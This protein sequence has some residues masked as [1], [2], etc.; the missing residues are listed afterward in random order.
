MIKGSTSAC[1]HPDVN[2]AS[3]EC[4]LNILIANKVSQRPPAITPEKIRLEHKSLHISCLYPAMK[5]ESKTNL[6]LAILVLLSLQK[7]ATLDGQ[8]SVKNSTANINVCS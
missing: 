2:G 4:P 6:Y 3:I 7:S 1:W 8:F 5:R